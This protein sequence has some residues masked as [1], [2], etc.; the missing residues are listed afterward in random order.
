MG[1]EPPKQE[2]KDSFGFV[3]TGPP[4]NMRQR[5][6]I[7]DSLTKIVTNAPKGRGRGNGSRGSHVATWGAGYMGQLG[8]GFIRGQK[9]YSAIPLILELDAVVR[10][11]ACGGLH[12]AAVTESGDVYTW[13]DGSRGQLGQSGSDS[14]AKQIPKSVG[15]SL[16]SVFIVQIACGGAHTCALTDTGFIYSWGW[17]KYGQT[18]HGDR[19]RSTNK[20]P[21]K[22]EHELARNIS[23]VACGS[24]H[25]LAID[26]NGLA[27]SFGCGEHGEIGHGDS[28]IRMLPTRIES[29]EKDQKVIT[30]LACGSIHSCL[31]TDDGE[32]WLCG[33]GE[34]FANESQ[35]FFYTPKKIEM[36]E[37]MTQISCG[38]SHNV[39]LSATGDVYV[40]GS[41]EYG[42]LGYG[43]CGNL[44]TPRLVL[45]D[46]N[47]AQVA[48]GRY[49][50]FALSA[51]GVLY[52]WGCGEN[53][54]L[55]LG[56]DEN[57]S[58]PT[59]VHP[60]LGT[61]VGQIACGEHHTAALTSAPWSKLSHDV[62]EWFTAAKAEHEFKLQF[63][64]D[65]HRGLNRKDLQQIKVD[66]VGWW[67]NYSERKEEQRLLDDEELERE[68]GTIQYQEEL[69]EEVGKE[70]DEKTH[71]RDIDNKLAMY[72]SATTKLPD[73]GKR[74]DRSKAGGTAGTMGE[75]DDLAST[76][77]L[78]KVSKKK[79][80]RKISSARSDRAPSKA[81]S[82]TTAEAAETAVSYGASAPVTRTNFLKET[83]LMVTRMK[84]VIED[85]SASQG[86]RYLQEMIRT[87]FDAR[88]EFDALRASARNMARRL[89]KYHK[90]LTLLKSSAELSDTSEEVMEKQL[91]GLR[92]QLNTVT[93]KI[94]ETSENRQNYE[95]NISHLKED[96]FAQFNQLK[97]LRKKYHE[98][99]NFHKKMTELKTQ[100]LVEKDEAEAELQEF[101]EEISNYQKF[102]NQQLEQFESILTIIRKQNDKREAAKQERTEKNRVKIAQRIE[103]LEAEAEAA[104]LE[105][106][107]LTSRLTSLDLKLRHFED[108]FQKIMAATGLTNP[109]AIVN[110]F[111]FKGEIKDQLQ[112]EIEDKEKL[113]EQLHAQYNECERQL[114]EAKKS[115]KDE[116]WRDVDV[117]AEGNRE[118]EHR[119]TK[120]KKEADQATQWLALLQEGLSTLCTNVCNVQ[121][122]TP[123][124]T[125]N[126]VWTPEQTVAMFEKLLPM[127][128]DLL[129]TEKEYNVK[130]EADKQAAAENA[131]KSNVAKLLA[132]AS[133]SSDYAQ[134]EQVKTGGG[135]GGGGD[136]DGDVDAGM[137]DDG[138]G[139]E[140]GGGGG[141]EKEASAAGN[142][143]A[144]ED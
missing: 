50:S 61:V 40:W 70:V 144:E 49:H 95:T 86:Q 16:D 60:I 116:S 8:I 13:G 136:A 111:F 7:F 91:S 62:A 108:S 74:N 57:V 71:E 12:T 10:Q 68:K 133:V 99:N 134:P 118:G 85:N 3:D 56:T 39:V 79:A 121:E 47:I 103:K 87:V 94:A 2:S 130:V 27:I 41:G 104:D 80:A 36:P 105:A 34:Y 135:N 77:K 20:V 123:Y 25:T 69:M 115:F 81:A 82:P 23:K 43:I 72:A 9:K 4:P 113:I 100:A 142:G 96:D 92:M 141:E 38:Q 102:V 138:K 45:Q 35:R 114:D 58:L 6:L 24:K 37:P 14:S 124:Q 30:Q 19:D 1:D 42:Q 11:V 143:E 73:V 53:G 28:D 65:T 52:S 137:N 67:K 140:G 22:I 119:M 66:M 128:D 129:D 17:P 55:G 93:I 75:K 127:M 98:S 64:K 31:I 26:R 110:K 59:V 106:G 126:S 83:A 97:E 139:G 33:F 109:D 5:E 120:S 78:P 84:T 32:V 21:R 29:L 88:K 46:K 51:L 90:E 117:A 112:G 15:G 76:V 132:V 107:G 89:D 125:I 122:V 44:S 48:A 54:Q 131:S 101:R 18:G 63:L